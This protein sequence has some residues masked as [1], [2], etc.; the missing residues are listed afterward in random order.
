MLDRIRQFFVSEDAG[1]EADDTAALHLA[2]AV[3]L[4]QVA[5]ADHSLEEL[6]LARMREVLVE[7]WGLGE[8][9]LEDLLAVADDTSEADVSLHTQIDLINSHFGIERKLDLVRGLWQV[10]CADGVIHHHEELLIRRL[11]DLLYVPHTQFIRAK[12]QALDSPA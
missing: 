8:R 10:A 1:G 7:Q 11:A 3:L 12:H 6:E 5:K 2:A 9:D 4:I